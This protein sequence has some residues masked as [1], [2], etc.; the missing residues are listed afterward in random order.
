MVFNF[1]PSTGQLVG[2]LHKQD[3]HILSY[4]EIYV[5]LEATTLLLL[6][7]YILLNLSTYIALKT[8]KVF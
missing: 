6:H 2:K 8:A 3:T 7:V 5:T 4:I 1:F